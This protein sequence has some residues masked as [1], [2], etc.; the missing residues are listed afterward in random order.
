MNNKWTVFFSHAHTQSGE[1]WPDKIYYV[2]KD[3]YFDV[4]KFQLHFLFDIELSV[5]THV[6]LIL[7]VW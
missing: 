6:S 2:T 1:N 4:E 3:D 7:R 5:K